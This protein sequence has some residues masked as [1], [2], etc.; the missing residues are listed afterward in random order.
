MRLSG[1][2]ISELAFPKRSMEKEAPRNLYRSV[3]DLRN[4]A[5]E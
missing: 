4:G 2:F 3:S 1:T 5:A